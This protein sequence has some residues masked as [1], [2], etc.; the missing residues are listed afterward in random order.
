MSYRDILT[1]LKGR[2]IEE[3]MDDFTSGA[4]YRYTKMS[5]AINRQFF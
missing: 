2:G 4:N 5:H 1:I 3:V